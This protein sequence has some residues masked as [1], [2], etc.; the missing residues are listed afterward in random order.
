MLGID[1]DDTLSPG[2]L[3]KV[4][5]GGSHSVSFRHA[6][7]DI[8]ELAESRVSAA[9]IRRATERIGQERVA[10]RQ[11]EVSFWNALGLPQKQ[12][13]PPGKTPPVVACVQMDGGRMQIFDRQESDAPAEKDASQ[14]GLWRENKVGCLLGMTSPVHEQDPCPQIPQTFVDPQRIAKLAR[15][16]KNAH[17]PARKR[18]EPAEKASVVDE[19][20]QERPRHWKAPEIVSKTVVATRQNIDVFG[21][22]LAATA[23]MLGFAAAARKAFVADGSD[24]NW[25]VWRKYF[26]HYTP[27]LD[28][29]HAICYVY[30]AALA[31]RT[32]EEA[33]P[34]Y[35]QWAQWVWAGEVAAVIAALRTRQEEIGLPQEADPATS[36]QKV[37][38]TA[39]GYLENQ[40]SRMKYAEYRQQGLPISSVHV[41]ST[42]KQINR[43][44]KGTEKFWSTGGGES[45]LQLSA[46]GL[47]DTLP[48]TV[49]WQQRYRNRSGQRS[50]AL[51][52][53]A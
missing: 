31:G 17:S 24:T 33:W 19:L 40:Q 53:A 8:F 3:R 29:V 25:S 35:C 18:Q 23:W 43:R 37:V 48:L 22:L 20:V 4:V 38:A 34:I 46:D 47:S 41:E 50:Y 10:Q 13:A 44:V 7:K 28:F 9:R 2:M 26:S 32:L 51:A 30:Q 5:Y 39:L 14:Q 11:A 52:T 6:E 16:I 27:I 42:I 21:P 49:F 15:E 45:L 36:P 1:P 12:Q